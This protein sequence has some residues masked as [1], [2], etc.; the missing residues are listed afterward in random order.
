MVNNPKSSC[1]EN[2]CLCKNRNIMQFNH[3]N[4]HFI[5]YSICIQYMHE[6]L[7]IILHKIH[8][9]LLTTLLRYFVGIS[10]GK[11]DSQTSTMK[12]WFS[13]HV[14]VLLAVHEGASDNRISI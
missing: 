10:S 11:F 4:Y 13:N 6:I 7:C 2:K 14:L 12:P 1:S 9:F 3:I 8:P 5:L